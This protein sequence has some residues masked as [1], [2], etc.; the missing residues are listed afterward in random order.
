MSQLY[1]QLL[2]LLSK[3]FLSLQYRFRIFQSKQYREDA[4]RFSAPLQLHDLVLAN[5]TFVFSPSEIFEQSKALEPIAGSSTDY[6][7]Y[8]DSNP[9]TLEL[10]RLIISQ[11]SP[12][13]VVETGVANGASTRTILKAFQDFGLSSSKLYSLDIDSRVVTDEFR[14]NENFNFILINEPQNFSDAM[15]KVPTIDIFYHD[16]DHSYANQMHEY[17]LAWEKL[18]YNGVLISDDVNWSNAFLD[19]SLLVKKRMFVLNDNTKFCG[20][21]FKN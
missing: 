20:I 11:I 9:K 10:L 2:R 8:Y 12:S 16:S 1:N 21:I 7:H 6:P 14:S 13:V 18:S 19:F 4:F 15:K 5:A 17:S 3:G